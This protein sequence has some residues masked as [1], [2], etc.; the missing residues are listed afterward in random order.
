M[1]NLFAPLQARP[2]CFLQVLSLTCGRPDL[3]E[4][5]DFSYE[6]APANRRDH[7]NDMTRIDAIAWVRTATATE[8]I[9]FEVKYADRFNS[10]V[11]D[12]RA[13]PNYRSLQKIRRCWR[14][15][16]LVCSQPRLNQLTRVHALAAS[17][18]AQQGDERLTLIGLHRAA[19]VNAAAMLSE[20]ASHSTDPVISITID[21]WISSMQS[22]VPPI[23][24]Y[25]DERYL[26]YER[27]ELLWREFRS[28]VSNAAH[29]GSVP[30]GTV[31]VI[32]GS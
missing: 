7:L 26:R 25:L 32:A 19:D 20:Y 29:S 4:L 27:S 24:S 17:V 5:I 12:L 14:D 23:A 22:V 6:F 21:A 16:D 3:V 11:L 15:A 2:E 1:F 13:N 18:A 8:M 9:V 28:R 31:C 10:R 30:A